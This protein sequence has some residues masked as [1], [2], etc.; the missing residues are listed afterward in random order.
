MMRVI[1]RGYVLVLV[2]SSA[3]SWSAEQ[4]PSPASGGASA[5][6][7]STAA[8]APSLQQELGA[9][10]VFLPYPFSSKKGIYHS[11]VEYVWKIEVES[12]YHHCTA[13][14]NKAFQNPICKVG[15]AV[16]IE[17]TCD[18]L[19]SNLTVLAPSFAKK[20]RK[21]FIDRLRPDWIELNSRVKGD[22]RVIKLFDTLTKDEPLNVSALG[23]TKER[24]ER[25]ALKI[26]SKAE[27]VAGAGQSQGK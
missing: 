16:D 17:A 1:H 4:T 15:G 24:L 2:C 21:E 3:I 14:R 6:S 20:A 9:V 11:L 27:G 12:W 10:Y 23:A 8:P 19:R 25:E 18:Q 22:G 26:T 7:V 5:V 13:M